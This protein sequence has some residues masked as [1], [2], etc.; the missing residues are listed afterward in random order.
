MEE[1]PSWLGVYQLS[2]DMI[3]R[4]IVEVTFDDRNL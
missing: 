3:P 1:L 2:R 4:G